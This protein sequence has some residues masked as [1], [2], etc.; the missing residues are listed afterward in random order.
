MV[1]LRRTIRAVDCWQG[2]KR[3]MLPMTNI[4]SGCG[5][6]PGV[7]LFSMM[8]AVAGLVA[9]RR[10]TLCEKCAAFDDVMSSEVKE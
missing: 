6:A 1:R 8:Y 4:S 2:E 3:G 5:M 9:L 7:V 10:I